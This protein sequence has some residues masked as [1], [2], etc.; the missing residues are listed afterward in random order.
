M[1]LPSLTFHTG[2]L[3]QYYPDLAESFTKGFK[4]ARLPQEQRLKEQHAQELINQLLLGNEAAT[5]ENKYL[6]KKLEQLQEERGLKNIHQGLVNKYYGPTAEANI[7]LTRSQMDAN[8]ISNEIQRKTGLQ[9]AQADVLAQQLANKRTQVEEP[10]WQ[11]QIEADILSKQLSNMTPA[12]KTGAQLYGFGTPE[13]YDFIKRNEAIYEPPK[14]MAGNPLP[15]PPNSIP[16]QGMG[17]GV[18]RH[19]STIME[20]NIERG[21]SA[22]KALDTL[23]KLEIV[24]KKYPRLNR[25]FQAIATHPEDERMFSRLIKGLNEDEQTAIDLVRKYSSDLIVNLSSTA[26]TRATDA[27]RQLVKE[28]KP[29]VFMTGKANQEVINNTRDSIR[30][31]AEYAEVA[32][33]FSGTYYV[34]YIPQQYSNKKKIKNSSSNYNQEDI[35]YTAK[36]YNLSEEEVM[37]RLDESNQG[38]K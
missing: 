25:S 1:A 24:V 27:Y 22:Q 17:E 32:A 34:P 23:D 10:Y 6:P 28:S 14:D 19:Y 18:K 35:A 16:M 26:N 5:L 9:K 12:M 31:I 13:Y 36:K 4:A 15:L 21:I 8:L 2:E 20:K 29:G 38:F 30:P 3:G 33:P 37:R 11:R 7:G